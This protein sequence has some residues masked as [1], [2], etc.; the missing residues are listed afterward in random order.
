MPAHS[1]RPPRTQLIGAIALALLLASVPARPLAAQDGATP[2]ATGPLLGPFTALRVAVLPVQLWRADT[3]GWSRSVEWARERLALDS[4]ISAALQERG[5]GRRWAYSEDVVRSAR[6]NVTYA[7][8][9]YALGAG[10]WRTTPPK[11]GEALPPTLADNLRPLTALGDTRYALIP[12]ELRAEGEAVVLRLVLA[13]TRSRVV[14][15]AG[16][17]LSPGGPR[18]A[19]ALAERV[20]DLVLEP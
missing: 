19:A 3:A 13:D 18:Y 4:A 20:A 12:V 8:D 17:L 11:G 1:T 7:T 15:W 14:V 10:R 2:A 16:D 9:P 6:R 5:L